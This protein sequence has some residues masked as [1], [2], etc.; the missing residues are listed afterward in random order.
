MRNM[1]GKSLL[2]ALVLSG[3]ALA[4]GV[5]VSGTVRGA[6]GTP[7]RGVTVRVQGTQVRA[8]TDIE[9]KYSIT[10]PN[11]AVLS[12]SA[13]G[14]RPIQQGV[15]NRQ[16]VDITMEQV[17]Y[18]EEVTVTGYT[19]QRRSDIT[20]A[21]GGVNVDAV[22][23]QTGASVLQRLDAN[24][25]GVTVEASGSPGSRSTVRVR[26]IS[27]F[28]N[29]DPLYIVDG[30]P[31][32]DSYVNWLNPNDIAS[33][34]VLK[35]A[36]AASIYGAR[37]SN[38]VIV[39]ETSRKGAVGSPQARLSMRTGIATPTRGYDDILLQDALSYH[40]IVRAAHNN[41]KV[42]VPTNIYGDS[43]NPTV[44]TFT[45]A[46]PSLVTA[47]DAFGRPTQVN[48]A[49][50]AFPRPGGAACCLIMPG[51]AGT[52]WWDAV[53]SPAQVQ[54]VNLDIS[55][56][57]DDNAYGVSFNYFDQEGTA[58]FNRFKRGSMRV[59]TSFIRDKLNF[60]ENI[61]ISVDRQNGGVPNDPGGFAE[62]GILGKN[63]LMQPVVPVNDIA[64]NFASGKAVGLGNQTN[65]LKS[66]W[67]A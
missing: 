65:P 42:A 9:G 39:I 48:A 52:N 11:D 66:A 51:S 61:A 7:L 28:Q 18:L 46:D 30:V 6:S 64:G 55:G 12:F 43:L 44:P 13:L 23:R 67:G 27:S 57:G 8:I 1:L 41:A 14:R 35:D 22:V 25:S 37:A 63:I 58:A 50:Y 62:D 2:F 34:Q 45:Y 38:G 24:V 47:T 3:S 40:A 4:Q 32:Q 17:A 19:E 15:L 26:G 31:V 5:T 20:G 49:G 10:A 21:V 33:V 36:S 29:N 16:T 56:G 53:F 59:N 54:D 60:G